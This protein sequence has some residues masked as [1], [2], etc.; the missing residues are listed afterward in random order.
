MCS[1]GPVEPKVYKTQPVR[2]M[3]RS[4]P[5]ADPYVQESYIDADNESIISRW[6]VD[7]DVRN[8]IYNDDGSLAQVHEDFIINMC[9]SR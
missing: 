3:A 5:Y 1:T 4:R 2:S 6:S 9:R 8:L 7:D